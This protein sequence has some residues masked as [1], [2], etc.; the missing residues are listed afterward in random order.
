[1]VL[2]PES[3]EYGPVGAEERVVLDPTRQSTQLPYYSDRISGPSGGPNAGGEQTVV[4]PRSEDP[5]RKSRTTLSSYS[6]YSDDDDN[7]R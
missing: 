7:E 6:R 2:R 5:F 3:P 4:V 1:M